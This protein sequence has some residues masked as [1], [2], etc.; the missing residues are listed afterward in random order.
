MANRFQKLLFSFSSLSPVILI[1][2]IVFFCKGGE[3][4]LFIILIV[5]SVTLFI[6]GGV[7]FLRV[8][9]KGVETV[10]YS[11][12]IAS[13]KPDTEGLS[14]LIGAYAI[15]LVSTFA[16]NSNFMPFAFV[17]IALTLILFL[18]NSIPPVIFLTIMGYRFY[19]LALCSGLS[20]VHLISKRK[21]LRSS[22]AICEAKWLF[23]D[24][25]WLLDE[26]TR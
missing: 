10:D 19:T 1:F 6:V 7:V 26:R 4:H 17:V 16:D 14:S 11:G 21:C 3:L 15:P 12:Q 8:C 2:A 22:S 18:S 23:A 9:E 5:L 24:D 25:Y 13:I 20:G